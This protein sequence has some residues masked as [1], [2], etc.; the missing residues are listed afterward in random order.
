MPNGVDLDFCRLFQQNLHR[1]KQNAKRAGAQ[2]AFELLLRSPL[3]NETKGVLLPELLVEM[4]AQTTGRFSDLI[5]QRG[6]CL[7]E[8]CA[9]VRVSLGP[10]RHKSHCGYPREDGHAR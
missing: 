6:D 9:F 4:T 7:R 1:A 2:V 5:E 3:L 8:F 10:D